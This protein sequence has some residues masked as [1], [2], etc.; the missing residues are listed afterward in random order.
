MVWRGKTRGKQGRHQDNDVTKT[1]GKNKKSCTVKTRSNVK[2]GVETRAIQWYNK[3]K[4][5]NTRTK[6]SGNRRTKVLRWESGNIEK[7]M[8]N[9]C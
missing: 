7:K 4:E 5:K 8:E 9:K 3:F 2:T 6:A 1:K